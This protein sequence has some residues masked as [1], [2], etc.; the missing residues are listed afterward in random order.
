M[1]LVPKLSKIATTLAVFRFQ[2]SGSWHE[3]QLA[4]SGR[5]L[6]HLERSTTDHY[7]A[8][9]SFHT[10]LPVLVVQTCNVAE[11]LPTL[12]LWNIDCGRSSL[13]GCSRR[14]GR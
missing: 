3:A 10:T 6:G 8:G 14:N 7:F 1:L 5:L 4:S 13:Q 11:K 9:W 12:M 2:D